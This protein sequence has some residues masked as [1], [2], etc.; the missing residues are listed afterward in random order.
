MNVPDDIAC[1]VCGSKMVA[2]LKPWEEE[3]IKLMKKHAGSAS[4]EEVKRIRRVY[5]NANFVRSYGK[6][7]VIALASRGVG[8]ETASRI[9]QK[10]RAEEEDFYR[11][12]M[13]AERNYAKTKKF[14][15]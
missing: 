5:R 11:D 2:A 1:P 12:I 3:E 15:D 8:P 4:N 10:N 7:A 14:W 6:K 9:I 13:A